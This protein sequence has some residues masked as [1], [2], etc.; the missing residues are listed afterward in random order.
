MKQ[1]INKKPQFS[2]RESSEEEADSLLKTIP[3]KILEDAF[4]LEKERKEKEYSY[5]ALPKE[6]DA[7]EKDA[8]IYYLVNY[9]EIPYLLVG[10]NPRPVFQISSLARIADKVN[11]N[12]AADCL[13]ELILHKLVP[14]CNGKT[15]R[16]E[17][18]TALTNY[19]G[20]TVFEK[21]KR[22][23][24]EGVEIF[25]S[26]KPTNQDWKGKEYWSCRIDIK[27]PSQI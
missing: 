3:A 5:W 25:V 9:N 14:K 4:H 12:A 2:V 1:Q 18:I 24:I 7:A 22:R 11:E 6:E 20:R 17:F 19:G 15:P 26:E 16:Q 13:Q 10:I 21:L 23:T 8:R 27:D